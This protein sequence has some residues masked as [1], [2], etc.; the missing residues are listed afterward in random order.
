VVEPVVLE[1]RQPAAANT[2]QSLDI[3][4]PM[5]LPRARARHVNWAI[6]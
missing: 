5:H 4:L 6:G 2:R 3:L 1:R